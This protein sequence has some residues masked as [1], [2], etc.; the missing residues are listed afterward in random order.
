MASTGTKTDMTESKTEVPV[1]TVEIT[2]L[3]SPAVVA[4]EARREVEVDVLIAAAVPPPAMI[5]R[6]Q[7]KKGS[8]SETV[9]NMIAVPETAAKGTAMVS[10]I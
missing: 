8:I 5:A 10:R 4:V 7:V 1:S 6:I 9:D 2:G 3:A